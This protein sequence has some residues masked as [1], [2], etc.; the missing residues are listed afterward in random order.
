MAQKLGTEGGREV[1]G[2]DLWLR[3]CEQEI[4]KLSEITPICGTFI[5]RDIR[6]NNEADF[7]RK[8]GGT[9]IHVERPSLGDTGVVRDHVS[10][11]GVEFN[12]RTDIKII[13]NGSLE[14]LEQ[15]VFS[16][17]THMSLTR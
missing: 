4:Y 15:T 16:T 17:L 13:N 11:R 9:I 5:I 3:R 7:V 10:E 2:E 6:F 12:K 8:R 1:F 14:Q